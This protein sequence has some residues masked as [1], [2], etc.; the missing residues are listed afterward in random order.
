MRMND[1]LASLRPAQWL[2]NLVVFAALIFSLNVFN[3]N[4][5]VRT[6]VAFALFCF[7]SSAMYLVNDVR[8]REKDRF[9][10]LKA[11]RSIASGR[12]PARQAVIVAFVL[13]AGSLLGSWFLAPLLTTILAAY[14]IVQLLYTYGLKHFVILDVMAIAVGFV[15]RAIA[16]AV[17]IDV[18]I[19]HWLLAATLL[20]ALF[21]GFGKRR[22]ELVAL[23]SNANSHR[24]V[25][26]QYAKMFLDQMIAVVTAST[27]IVYLL[28]T[29]SDEVREK[30]GTTNLIYTVPFVLYGIF[31]YLY[32]IHKRESGGDPSKTLLTDGPLLASVG[33]W[34]ATVIA[35]LYR[36]M[37]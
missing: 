26:E 32:L 12:F 27:V 3:G 17:T 29:T 30:F 13:M 36:S 24:P 9:H 4:L 31:R 14:L 22:Y 10:P 23:A 33:L 7:T 34:V 18:P 16:G 11:S 21:L 5:L 25:L 8:D 15:L 20:L 35:I 2:K 6:L 28:Y 1:L 37:A 19:S